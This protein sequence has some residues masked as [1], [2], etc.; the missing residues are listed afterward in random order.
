MIQSAAVKG[1][2]L[3]V[4]AV[5]DSAEHLAALHAIMAR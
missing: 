5:F 2:E 3:A 4:M 1:F